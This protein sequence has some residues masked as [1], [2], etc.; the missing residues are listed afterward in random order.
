VPLTPRD[1]IDRHRAAELA[2]TASQI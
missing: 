2:R 1:K